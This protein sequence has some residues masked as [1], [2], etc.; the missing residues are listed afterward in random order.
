MER[1][2]RNIS[3][4]YRYGQRFFNRLMRGT[5]V[6]VGQMA[7]LVQIYRTPGITQDEISANLGMDKGTT[8]RNLH[9]MEQQ[10]LAVRM[11][12]KADRRVNHIY[13]SEK[14]EAYYPAIMEAI[15]KL[16]EVLYRGFSEDEISMAVE[17]LARMQSNLCSEL[18]GGKK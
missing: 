4:L 16:H 9:Q 6:E 11:P 18:E 1:I 14:G 13:L 3:I 15:E 7:T 12:D 2:N 17:L 8:A 5:G 10:G